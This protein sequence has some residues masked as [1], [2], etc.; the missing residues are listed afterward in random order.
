MFGIIIDSFSEI[1]NQSRD[2]ADNIENICFICELERD[3]LEKVGIS[4]DQHIS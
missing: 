4:F 2:L 3:S 1:F